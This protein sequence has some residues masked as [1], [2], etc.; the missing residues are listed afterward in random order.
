M[1]WTLI[2]LILLLVV[3]LFG[4]ALLGTVLSII[5]TLVWAILGAILTVI[6]VFLKLLFTP[7]LGLIF[8]G[9]LIWFLVYRRRDSSQPEIKS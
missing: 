3:A 7:F 4:F 1:K 9:A 6:G 2:P 8:L 5:G